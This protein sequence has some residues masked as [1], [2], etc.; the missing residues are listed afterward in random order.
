M[1]TMVIGPPK[2][3]EIGFFRE[4]FQD[5]G[6]TMVIGPPKEFEQIRMDL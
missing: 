1:N 2:E 4:V 3:F 6:N 5:V